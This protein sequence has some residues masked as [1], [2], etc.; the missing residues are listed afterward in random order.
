MRTLL[1]PRDVELRPKS[2]ALLKEIG[3]KIHAQKDGSRL[4]YAEGVAQVV[5]CVLETEKPFLTHPLALRGV[6][7]ALASISRESAESSPKA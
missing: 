6:E 7:T 1:L 3:V 2:V 5:S 4:D